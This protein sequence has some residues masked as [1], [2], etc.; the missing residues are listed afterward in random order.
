VTRPRD[1]SGKDVP[2][3][4]ADGVTHRYRR[5]RAPALDDVDLAIPQGSIT[6]LVGPNGAG[7]ST[8]MRAWLG[9]ERPARGRLGI[10][11]HDL[12]TQRAAAVELVG[13]LSQSGGIYSG[14]DADAHFRLATSLHDGFD[15]TLARTVLEELGTPRGQ[16]AGSLSGGQQKHVELAIALGTHAPVLLLDEPMASLDAFARNEFLR[17]LAREI[18]SSGRTAVLSSHIVRDIE[19]VCDRLVILCAGRVRLH[20]TIAEALA[21]HRILDGASPPVPEGSDLVGRFRQLDGE[22]RTVVRSTATGLPSP[23]LEEL[24]MA[25]L[26]QTAGNQ[27]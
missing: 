18:R 14:L 3:L 7:K 17:V 2:A 15:G 24:V 12:A 25:H 9:F 6:A 21:M 10:L 20:E 4:S 27:A 16:R 13:F 26:A 8:L 19:M 1:G 22:L 5:R 23:T 11:G